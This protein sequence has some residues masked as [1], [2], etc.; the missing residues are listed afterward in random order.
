MKRNA[1]GETGVIS[2]KVLMQRAV[3]T[4]FKNKAL[5]LL[6]VKPVVLNW[7]LEQKRDIKGKTGE[8]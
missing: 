5:L 7:I 3:R 8:I 6:R 2:H 1:A 4:F